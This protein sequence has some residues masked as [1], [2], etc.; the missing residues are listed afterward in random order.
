ML[1]ATNEERGTVAA[2]GALSRDLDDRYED[3]TSSYSLYSKGIT[4]G[5]A[6]DRPFMLSPRREQKI[7]S[8]VTYRRLAQ[9]LT[10]L[11]PDTPVH[12][13]SDR[14]MDFRSIP[15]DQNAIFYDYVV[16]KSVR[17]YSSRAV[18]TNRASLV[19]V[20]LTC[21]GIAHIQCGEILELFEFDEG[22]R[23][24]PIWIAHMRWF[25][26]WNGPREV[27]WDEL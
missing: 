2:L 16:Y 5:F 9:M 7:M 27:V 3:G 26:E 18:G 4:V 20:D 21:S 25:R 22:K 19:E 12:C 6:A 24:S 13:Q 14:P 17:Y 11:H 8:T 23:G 10:S 15:I 1:K